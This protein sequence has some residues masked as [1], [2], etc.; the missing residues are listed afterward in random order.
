MKIAKNSKIRHLYKPIS[1]LRIEK[2]YFLFKI[3]LRKK[4]YI[5]TYN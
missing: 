2:L 4:K 5:F 3:N 1:F